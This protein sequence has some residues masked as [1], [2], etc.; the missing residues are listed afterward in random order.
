MVDVLTEIEIRRSLAVVAA[1]AADPDNAPAWYENIKSVEWKTEKPLKTGSRIA[2]VAHFLGR[3]LEYTYEVTTWL[4]GESLVMQT[5]QG[6]FPMQT[7]YTWTAVDAGTTRMSLRNTGRPSGFSRLMTP[8]MSLM[9]R[10][11]NQK[12]LKKLKSILESN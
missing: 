9:M 11:A 7:T 2:F 8:L 12:D 4:P 5:A 10:K 1:Y 3:K 6:P